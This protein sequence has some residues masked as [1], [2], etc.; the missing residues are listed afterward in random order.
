LNLTQALEVHPLLAYEQAKWNL[1]YQLVAGIDEA[2]RGPL[3][4]PVV[5][6]SLV[7]LCPS[8]SIEGINDSK[9]LTPSKRQQIAEALRAESSVAYG[10][11]VA[12]HVEID[13]MNILEATRLAMRKSLEALPCDPDYLLVDGMP[14]SFEI[15]SEGI[16]KGDSKSLSIAAASILAKVTRDEMMLEYDR[17]WPQYG[18]AKHKGYG[19]KGHIEA[20]EKHGPCEIHRK[21]FAPVAKYTT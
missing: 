2:G 11:G 16:I 3:A 4:G 8:L 20:L 19:T 9:K 12:T 5:A 18:F 15:S 1:G 6:C 14:L 13:R 17:S 7:I 21:S 10:I